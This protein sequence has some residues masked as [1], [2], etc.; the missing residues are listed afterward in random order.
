MVQV[1]ACMCMQAVIFAIRVIFFFL[2]CFDKRGDAL[3][4]VVQEEA[5]IDLRTY[6]FGIHCLKHMGRAA[7]RDVFLR[8][9]HATGFTVMGGGG[10]EGCYPGLGTRGE[11]AASHDGGNFPHAPSFCGTLVCIR[12]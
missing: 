9:F 2:L 11:L 12:Q 8:S 6:R 3:T 10:K 7:P 5:R 4:L 1:R